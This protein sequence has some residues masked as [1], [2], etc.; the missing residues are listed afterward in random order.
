MT[1]ATAGRIHSVTVDRHDVGRHR[2][3]G[4]QRDRFLAQRGQHPLD[5]VQEDPARA[6][7]EHAA[8]LE[9]APVRVEQVG[10]PVQRH[11]RLSGAGTAGDHGEALPGS[12]D[13][14]VLLGLD[15]G[16]DVAHG[17]AAGACQGREQGAV[18]D[19]YQIGAVRVAIQQVVLDP[20]HPVT[21]AAQ[22]SASDDMH[23]IGRCRPV[24]RL[25]G[26]GA[27]VDHQGFVVGVANPDPAD[28]ADLTVCPIEPAEDQP[29]VLGVEHGEPLGRLEREHITLVET[30]AVLLADEGTAVG[31]IER[32]SGRSHL[33]RGASGLG[34]TCVDKIDMRLLLGQLALDRA[35]VL[36]QEERSLLRG[37]TSEYR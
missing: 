21:A 29:L 31:L 8:R 14:L 27:P 5:V 11:D 1:A 30:G 3:D 32:P 4:A 19:H 20:D 35:G 15:G 6:H 25:G 37:R 13:R 36:S 24:E 18:A 33:L 17:V 22:H 9:A 7:D 12:P 10:R 16:D 2:P 28:V 26:R 34:E 23:G